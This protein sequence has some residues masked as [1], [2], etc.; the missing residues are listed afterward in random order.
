MTCL[1]IEL[2]CFGF[3]YE[4][5]LKKDLGLQISV[6]YGFS[7]TECETKSFNDCLING[8]K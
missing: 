5:R 4:M 7:G 3:L 1:C 8:I 6:V 2:E